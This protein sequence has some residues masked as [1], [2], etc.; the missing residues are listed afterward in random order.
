MIVNRVINDINI[1]VDIS[2]GDILYFDAEFVNTLPSGG[3]NDILYA[4][5]QKKGIYRP[6]SLMIELTGKCNF[7]C[8]FC[9]ITTSQQ[10]L[11]CKTKVFEEIKDDLIYLI[12]NG[13][14]SCTIT[15][16]E[17]LMHP[18]FSKIYR[19]LKERGVLVTVLTNLS[20][21]N[22]D[23]IKLFEELPPY[24]IDVSLYAYNEDEMKKT[25]LQ[26][27][28]SASHILSNVLLLKQKN[29]KVTCKT[30]S[31]K[32]TINEIPL[33]ENWCKNHGIPYFYSLETFENYDGK[34]MSVY[35]LPQ[36]DIELDRVVAAKSKYS[37]VFSFFGKKLNFDCKGGQYGIFMS[38]DYK[39][40]P[41]MPFYS[42]SA[43][44]FAVVPGNIDTAIKDLQL[45]INR[46]SNTPLKGCSG[47]NSFNICQSCVITQLLDE[48]N[49][50]N[51]T[52]ISC[53]RNRQ[54]GSEIV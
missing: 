33:L 48:E 8:P 3:I 32:L 18:D 19:L 21:L 13:L 14:L 5:Y 28:I 1:S 35:A 25:T 29:L 41:C 24:K 2:K 16:G 6:L 26:S 4:L 23:L 37:E 53:Q 9:Y 34:E 27:K 22:H 12:D 42:V 50:L 43:A 40:R 7:K 11:S 52:E 20:L 49:N 17:C 47:C 36:K 51:I 38:Y 31:N 44:N 30:P 45:F 54:L 15:G 39:I 10:A 46:Y